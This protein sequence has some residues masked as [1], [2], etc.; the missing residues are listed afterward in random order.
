MRYVSEAMNSGFVSSVGPHVVQFEKEFAK[1]LNVKFAVACSSGTAALHIALLIKGIKNGD[2]VLIPNMTFIATA[3]A[4]AY[5]GA[6]PVFLD[7]DPQNLGISVKSLEDFISKF[8]YFDGKNLINKKTKKRIKGCIPVHLLGCPA[9]M[10]SINKICIDNKIE[11]IEDAAESLGSEYKGRM[12][13]TL[14]D[15]GCFSFNGNKIITTGGGGMIVTNNEELAIK[16][17]HLT[18]TAKTDPIFFEH[19]EIG[20]NYRMVNILAAIGIGQLS[21]IENFLNKKRETHRKYFRL[22][23]NINGISLFTSPKKYYSN[24]WLNMISFEDYILE[25]YS[26]KDLVMHFNNRNIQTRPIW[27]L[28]RNMPMYKNCFSMHQSQSENLYKRSIV[29][30]S[31]TNIKDDEIELVTEAIKDLS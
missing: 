11:V 30:P 31:S 12:C 6:K 18:T 15:L 1:Y 21:R 16:A 25:R 4:V 14:S 17:K 13:G 9:D 22:F 26:L 7:I 5:I 23:K 19:D 28:L 29:I 10:D 8:T 3:N 20:Y 27:T 2:E 24:Y